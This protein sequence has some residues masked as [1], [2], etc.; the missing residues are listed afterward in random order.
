MKPAAIHFGVGLALMVATRTRHETEV[1]GVRFG[2]NTA[3]NGR[4]LAKRSQDG[5]Y[6][7][8]ARLMIPWKRGHYHTS[9]GSPGTGLSTAGAIGRRDDRLGSRRP[10]RSRSRGPS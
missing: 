3:F 7:P 5:T 9:A 4:V 1:S 2:R 8:S 10:A 6:P